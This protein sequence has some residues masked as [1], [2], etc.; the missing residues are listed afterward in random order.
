MQPALFFS[1]DGG[2]MFLLQGVEWLF[3]CLLGSIKESFISRQ[4]LVVTKGVQH[5]WFYRLHT[6]PNVTGCR[7]KHLAFIGNKDTE[8]PPPY[9][10]NPYDLTMFLQTRLETHFKKP[11][12]S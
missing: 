4:R 12:K 5:F 2:A 8:I 7:Q 9:Q 3:S 6:I 11:P 1:S 10:W